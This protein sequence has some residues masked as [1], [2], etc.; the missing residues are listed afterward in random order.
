MYTSF[1]FFFPLVCL[2]GECARGW[3]VSHT[4][5]LRALLFSASSLLKVESWW[6][7]CC[8][9]FYYRTKQNDNSKLKS[10]GLKRKNKG[11]TRGNTKR[12]CAGGTEPSVRPLRSLRLF[13]FFALYLQSQTNP[14][15]RWNR[16]TSHTDPRKK[17]KR[18]TCKCAGAPLLIYSF[19]PPP[20]PYACAT[21]PLFSFS[22]KKKKEAILEKGRWWCVLKA[23]SFTHL[24]VIIVTIAVYLVKKRKKNYGKHGLLITLFFFFTFI[25]N[26]ISC[27]SFHFIFISFHFVFIS[28]CLYL[29]FPHTSPRSVTLEVVLTFASRR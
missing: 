14:H 12:N 29:P 19:F 7:V 6:G 10:T 16:I 25:S 15:E 22:K 28:F 8:Q 23:V 17:K 4:S 21:S 11:L 18:K 20:V 13:F 27:F 26:F 3:C 9:S 24:P 1:C 5:T 2:L